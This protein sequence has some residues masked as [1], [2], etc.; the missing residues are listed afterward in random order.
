MKFINLAKVG[1]FAVGGLMAV[2]AGSA[3]AAVGA[4]AGGEM[5]YAFRGLSIDGHNMMINQVASYSCMDS[6]YGTEG[7]YWSNL[8]N[9]DR[10]TCDSNCATGHTS[11]TPGS[12]VTATATLRA[13]TAQVTSMISSRISAVK[14]ASLGLGGSAVSA[15]LD[16][17]ADG[18]LIGLSGGDKKRGIGVWVQGRFTSVEDDNAATKFDGTVYDVLVGADKQIGKKA[19]LGVAIGYEKSDLDTN[20][21]NGNI[22]GDGWL[23]SP[24]LSLNVNKAVSLDLSGGYAWLEY[25]MNRRD[26]N[27][28]ETFTGNTD[29]NRFWVNGQVNYDKVVKKALLGAFLGVNYS[30]EKRDAF[31]EASSNA[32]TGSVS[33]GASSTKLG[34]IRL[35]GTAEYNA[36]KV[37]PYVGL[38]AEYDYTKS[39]TVVAAN[40]A[41]PSDDDFGMVGRVGLNLVFSP[42]VSGVIE[43]SGSFLRDDYSEYSGLARL[44]VEF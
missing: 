40:Q 5:T 1:L 21:N 28:N 9:A 7:S 44:R 43:G 13:A 16:E 42:S 30:H 19:L 35:G 23:V 37:R 33:H 34:Q 2:Q 11:N 15:S 6:V 29:A 8:S 32:V 3:V 31:S 27:N 12:V 14:K 25:D 4:G 36:G 17:G 22:D 24:Y 38:T 41:A 26:T 20:Y 18:G 39:K 10:S